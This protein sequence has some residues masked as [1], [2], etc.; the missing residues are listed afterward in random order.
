MIKTFDNRYRLL[1]A[2]EGMIIVNKETG[3]G[4]YCIFLG[5]HDKEENYTEIPIDEYVEPEHPK[6]EGPI[7]YEKIDST[8]QD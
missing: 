8:I 2:E 3:M 5:I 6:P 7:S 1:M 4:S